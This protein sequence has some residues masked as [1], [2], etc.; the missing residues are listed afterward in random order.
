MEFETRFEINDKV[1]YCYGDNHKNCYR[2]IHDKGGDQMTES[3]YIFGY[4]Y[5]G[6]KLHNYLGKYDYILEE[7]ELENFIKNIACTVDEISK[8]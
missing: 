4:D 6:N 3:P 1:Y 7:C 8:Y 2:I 5:E